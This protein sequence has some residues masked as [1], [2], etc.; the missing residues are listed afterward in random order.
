MPGAAQR[1]RRAVTVKVRGSLHACRSRGRQTP[2]ANLGR[3]ATAGNNGIRK[4]LQR[5]GIVTSETA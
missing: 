3:L 1:G 5:E 4:S 2:V